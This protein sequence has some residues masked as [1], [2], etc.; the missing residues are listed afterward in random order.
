MFEAILTKPLYNALV[1]LVGVLPGASLA[2]SVVVLTVLVRFILVPLSKKSLLHQ[3]L[4]RKLQPY[5]QEIKQK[6]T[7]TKEQSAKI[8]ELYKANKSNPFS[9]CLTILVQLPILIA[10]YSVFF[11]GIEG[12]EELL[13][14]GL[15]V[16]ENLSTML[17]SIDLTEKS[18]LMALLTGLIQFL[19]ITFSPN[20]SKAAAPKVDYS[21][22]HPDDRFQAKLM[23]GMQ[24]G[25]RIAI[26][27]M[28]TIFAM[29]VPAA[30]ALYWMT[31]TSFMIFME[32]YFRAKVKNIEVVPLS[33]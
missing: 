26:P 32:L 21:Q 19:Q 9:G 14:A 22:I 11:R 25:T 31:S 7:D 29:F 20:M 16:P 1:W 17:L 2:L 23:N 18:V 13:Y 6:Y 8:M 33:E 12:S 15:Q 4:Q 5:I 30:V 3:A 27:L 10:V 24:R 28:I